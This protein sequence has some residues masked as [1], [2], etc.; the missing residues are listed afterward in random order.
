MR[1]ARR[2]HDADI[3]RPGH[4]IAFND[5]AH[6]LAWH[7]S[8][9]V[10]EEHLGDAADEEHAVPLLQVVGAQRVVRRLVDEETLEPRLGRRALGDRGRM[11]MKTFARAGI[12]QRRGP[13]LRPHAYLPEQAFALARELT[14]VTA[15]TLLKH[16]A[17]KHLHS[18]DAQLKW[19]GIAHQLTR[20]GATGVEFRLHVARVVITRGEFFLGERTECFPKIVGHGGMV[21]S[22]KRVSN[23][24]YTNKALVSQRLA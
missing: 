21:A 22:V 13:L 7:P 17:M 19:Q 12:H 5:E 8:A 9:L 3:V 14:E 6:L 2:D 10:D 23:S 11:D 15:I 1:D 20:I 4:V 16:A 24:F 18:R